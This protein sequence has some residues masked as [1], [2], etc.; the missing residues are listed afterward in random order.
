MIDGERTYVDRDPIDASNALKQHAAYCAL[1]GECGAAVRVLEMNRDLPDAV[2]VEDTAVVLDELAVMMSMGA[3]SRRREPAGIE[4]V[5]REYRDIARVELPATI[6]GGDV[7]V[8]ARTILVGASS[9]T[10]RAGIDA[11]AAIVTPLGY[12]VLGVPVTGCL[13]LKTACTALPDDRLIVNRDLID[14]RPLAGF[15]LVDVPPHEAYAADVAMVD[16]HVVVSAAYPDTAEL[17]A[18]SGY[19][20]RPIDVSEFAKAEGGVTCMSLIFAS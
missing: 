4:S 9:R 18:A 8:V 20:V 16:G 2:F 5:L 7:V 10:S 12:R 6:D 17:L 19:S 13:H 15:D 11:L 3:D 14:T 1:L